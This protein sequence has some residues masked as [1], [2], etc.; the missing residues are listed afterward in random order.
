M[1]QYLSYGEFKCFNQKEI[2]KF[3]VNSIEGNYI[4]GHILELD[5]EYFDELHQLHTDYP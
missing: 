5:L 4:D 3:N 1:S 2:D